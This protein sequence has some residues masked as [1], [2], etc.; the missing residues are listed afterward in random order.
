MINKWGNIYAKITILKNAIWK[1]CSKTWNI[2]REIMFKTQF[3][4]C[5]YDLVDYTAL[6]IV[7]Q[8]GILFASLWYSA[9][10]TQVQLCRTIFILQMEFVILREDLIFNSCFD[11]KRKN[12]YSVLLTLPRFYDC[13]HEMNQ[14]KRYYKY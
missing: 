5:L 1:G 9:E 3:V 7:A 8:I 13:I 14:F 12:L 6:C 11:K 4:L 2:K 10:D